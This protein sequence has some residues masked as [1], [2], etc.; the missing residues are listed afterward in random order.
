VSVRRVQFVHGLES[1]P[2]GSKARYL[3]EHFP[4]ALTPEMNTKDFEASVRVQLDALSEKAPDVLVGSSFGGAV[5]VALLQRGLWKGPTLLLAP[6][7]KHFGLEPRLPENVRVLIVH[8]TRDDVVDIE[9]SRVLAR[10]G[11]EN[12]VEMIELDDE[13]RLKSVLETELLTELVN[14]TAQ[15]V[16]ISGPA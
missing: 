14:R 10:T 2:L 4:D 5:A 7:V 16:M 9:T 15:P 8:G 13:H 3:A 1:G 6:A 11:S 12:L